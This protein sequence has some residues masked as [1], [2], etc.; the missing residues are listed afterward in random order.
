MYA[1]PTTIWYIS[2][3]SIIPC[4]SI[5]EKETLRIGAFLFVRCSYY[6]AVAPSAGAGSSP[7]W[8]AATSLSSVAS[9]AAASLAA[10]SAPGS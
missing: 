3:T 7:P 2:I 4:L 6:A 9:P 1:Y 10:A 8:S 5:Y